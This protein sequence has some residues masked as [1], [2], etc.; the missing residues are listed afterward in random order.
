MSGHRKFKD[1]RD[2]LVEQNPEIEGR[3]AEAREELN[4]AMSL[5]ELRHARELTQT[6]LAHALDVQQP[7]VSRIEHQTDLYV[8]TLRSYV[9]ALGGELQIVAQF[10]G[11][12]VMLNG[13]EQLEEPQGASVPRALY[14]A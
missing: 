8:S 14:G 2:R 7:A 1:L 10:G 5:A 11:T 13:F 3:I 9:E 12:A 6:Q 4:R